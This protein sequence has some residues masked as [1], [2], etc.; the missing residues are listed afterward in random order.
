M[1]P[2]QPMKEDSDDDDFILPTHDEAALRDADLEFVDV[3]MTSSS[4]S[5]S[6]SETKEDVGSLSPILHV[7]VLVV[8]E[9]PL[10]SNH[11]TTPISS[12][13]LSSSSQ[14][15]NHTKFGDSVEW[16]DIVDDDYFHA[17][18]AADE[19]SDWVLCAL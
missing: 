18:S 1:E 12:S 2:Q 8:V 15:P 16:I 14:S 5:S 7:D 4:S 10:E 13:S 17:R 11:H 3:V 6:T 9:E 19:T